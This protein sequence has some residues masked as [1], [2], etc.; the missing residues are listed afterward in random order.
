MRKQKETFENKEPTNNQEFLRTGE[1][2]AN[3]GAQF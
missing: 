1:V 3:Q 2:F